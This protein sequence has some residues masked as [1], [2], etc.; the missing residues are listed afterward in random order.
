MRKKEYILQNCAADLTEIASEV[1][2]ITLPD[3]YG[4]YQGK[5]EEAELENKKPDLELRKQELR[6]KD[7][8]YRSNRSKSKEQGDNS[9]GKSN[10]KD[11]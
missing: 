4:F 2:G 6:E 11:E 1:W 7:F 5:R 3:L 8:E 9:N 10:N